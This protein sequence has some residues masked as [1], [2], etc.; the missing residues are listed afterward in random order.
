[1]SDVFDSS[2][3]ERAFAKWEKETYGDL[4][5]RIP[6]AVQLQAYNQAQTGQQ[7]FDAASRPGPYQAA[8]HQWE[9]NMVQVYTVLAKEGVLRSGEVNC[10]HEQCAKNILDISSIDESEAPGP[11]MKSWCTEDLSETLQQRV[12]AIQQ[13][14]TDEASRR[15]SNISRGLG[16]LFALDARETAQAAASRFAA[17]EKMAC[18][19]SHESC[20]APGAGGKGDSCHGK[21]PCKS[22]CCAEHDGLVPAR[23]GAI[24]PDTAH[25]LG[26]EALSRNECGSRNQCETGRFQGLEALD[27][28]EKNNIP[29]EW[30]ASD[31][32][33]M[34]ARAR[35]H[36]LQTLSAL[37]APEPVTCKSP[38]PAK[39]G[40]LKRH[41]YELPKEKANMF[42]TTTG[43]WEDS[44]LMPQTVNTT[45][46]DISETTT[47]TGAMMEFLGPNVGASLPFANDAST[48]RIP[49]PNL[50][51]DEELDLQML[52]G[53]NDGDITPE[54]LDEFMNAAM[55][56]EHDGGLD[57]GE[58]DMSWVNAA[59]MTAGA[60]KE[61]AAHQDTVMGDLDFDEMVFDFGTGDAI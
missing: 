47:S 48:S 56:G 43:A 37:E 53:G 16:S 5:L 27:R 10:G 36:G 55:S 51:P 8:L 2:T 38:L 21:Y 42:A 13:S 44:G 24:S 26:L 35:S 19:H 41:K 49:L 34:A 17:L 11:Q 20:D 33:T 46:P 57:S 4:G 45:L 52:D 32:A 25:T 18:M 58:I 23:D 3:I 40:Y 29:C 1:M 12:L 54:Q 60:P 50:T 61:P 30:L 6:F 15:H 59:M 7:K 28:Y 31:L 39:K 9:A 22:Y 14:Q